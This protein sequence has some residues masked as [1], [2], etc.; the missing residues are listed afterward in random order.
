VNAAVAPTTAEGPL[1]RGIFRNNILRA[2][3]CET[4]FDFREE[5]VGVSPRLLENNDLDPVPLPTG[6]YLNNS[7]LIP[8]GQGQIV[9]SIVGVNGLVS[10]SKNISADPLFVGFPGNPRLGVTSPC[11]DKGTVTDAPSTDFDGK[12]R[13]GTPDIGA[14][15]E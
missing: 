11:I 5:T 7:P 9:I 4:S 13:T 2:G 14:F 15:E 3:G 10:S 6:L 12:M 1:R 8:G